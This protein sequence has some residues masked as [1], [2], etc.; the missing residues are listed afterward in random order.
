MVS[1]H[2]PA[3]ATSGRR[4]GLTSPNLTAQD[5]PK[6]SGGSGTLT[7][8][9]LAGVVVSIVCTVLGLIITIIFKVIQHRKRN[10]SPDNRY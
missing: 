1:F 2:I 4:L 10:A 6:A 7:V 3:D 5:P 8:A 9:Q